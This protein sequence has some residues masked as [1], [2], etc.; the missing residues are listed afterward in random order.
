[1]SADTLVYNLSNSIERDDG[2]FI[3][4]DW[5]KVID[6][7]NGNYND[8]QSLLET[9]SISSSQS[10]LDYRQGYLAIPLVLTA[11][12]A[13]T[14]NSST[15][16]L[17]NIATASQSCA[18]SFGLKNSY[19][20]LI[21]SVSLDING[22]NIIQQSAYSALYNNFQ[23]LTSL[24]LNDIKT[25]GASIGLSTPSFL[26]WNY[27]SAA[28]AS[29]IGVTNN[30][31]Q[32]QAV[33]TGGTSYNGYDRGNKGLVERLQYI[34]Y[35]VDSLTGSSNVAYSNLQVSSYS[36]GL[37]RNRIYKKVSG[38]NAAEAAGAQY[39]QYQVQ[40]MAI[41][42]LRH[43]HNLF[44]VMP[45]CRGLNMKFTLNFNQA[46]TTI[47]VDSSRNLSHTNNF[48]SFNGINPLLVTSALTGVAPTT[49]I[50]A[51]AAQPNFNAISAV[52]GTF[53]LSLYVGNKTLDSTQY[54]IIGTNTALPNYVS[55]YVPALSMNPVYERLYLTNP[56]KEVIYN[57]VYTF[58]IQ[59]VTK[60][61]AFQSLIT[62]GIK[63]IK[64]VLIVPFYDQSVAG[65]N[66][67]QSP[68]DDNTIGTSP[69]THISQLQIQISGQNIFYNNVL[70]NFENFLENLYGVNAVNGGL[71][72]GVNSGLLSQL[73][74]DV[75]TANYYVADTSRGLPIEKDIAHSI[76]V[77]GT[78]TSEFTM[79]YYVFVTYENKFTINTSTGLIV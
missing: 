16:P 78:N 64:Q 67:I 75:G 55:L 61:T 54:A 47:T 74:F 17:G 15:Q 50:S 53:R 73:D 71:T 28:N 6:S 8:S 58:Q 60:A 2:I 44:N 30:R 5:L 21:H 40:I 37:Y 62:S 70:Y 45:L 33:V 46:V 26:S 51:Q 19:L 77:S 79:Q 29:G 42:K 57:D 22:I 59:N 63:N 9:S 23:L 12:S 10:W 65:G 56:N 38:S 25:Q 72:D 4:K 11:T 69:L 34:N 31:V 49:A 35:D 20:S 24:S 36:D 32:T 76:I 52:A 14:G 27:H 68:W 41:I 39:A 3:K 66:P 7:K 48:L 43:L 13:G 1:M 18:Y